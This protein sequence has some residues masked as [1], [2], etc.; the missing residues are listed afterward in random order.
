MLEPTSRQRRRLTPA[1]FALLLLAARSAPAD[2]RPG[3][4]TRDRLLNWNAFAVDTSGLDHTPPL[5]G[6]LRV[7]GEQVGPGRSSRAMAI[8]HIAIFDAVSAIDGRFR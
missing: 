7:Y 6:E 8:V 3:R 2:D 4:A 1:L 5:P